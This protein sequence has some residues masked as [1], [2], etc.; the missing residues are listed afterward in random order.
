MLMEE[1]K[2][3]QRENAELRREVRELHL[4]LREANNEIAQLESKA[5]ALAVAGDK[6]ENAL[7]ALL[8]DIQAKNFAY[9]TFGEYR[10]GAICGDMTL[11][12]ARAAQ[13]ELAALRR[14]EETKSK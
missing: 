2:R 5:N 7:L 14:H 10:E 11:G 12:T 9:I 1:N 6:T 13:R 8:D 3:L 4:K